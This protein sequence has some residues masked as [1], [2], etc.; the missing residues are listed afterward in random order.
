M[1]VTCRSCGANIT[2]K[3]RLP[4][5]KCSGPCEN[6]YHVKCA[7]ISQ[8]LLSDINN[9]TV[10]WLCE[11]CR[12]QS[13]QSVID[14]EISDSECDVNVSLADIM[15]QLKRMEKKLS[16]LDK[17]KDAVHTLQAANDALTSKL[18]HLEDQFSIHSAKLHQMEADYDK[19]AQMLNASS[20]TIS[21]LPMEHVDISGM[22]FNTISKVENSIQPDDILSIEPIRRNVSK[23]T[24]N[25]T[26][27]YVTRHN[28]FIVKLKSI[29]LQQKVLTQMRKIKTLYTKDLDII[30]PQNH[31]EHQIHIMHRLS[32]FQSQLYHEAKNIKL[33]SNF[34]YLWCK[35]G[36]IYLKKSADSDV[37]R[38]HSMNDIFRIQNIIH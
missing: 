13:S 3:G 18:K 7:C 2:K 24:L 32:K 22:I 30:L 34:K 31:R 37:Y 11:S 16:A 23:T 38:I 17:V 33:S 28:F 8:E 10:N 29:D 12:L 35:A 9:R 20:I 14:N 21:G 19:P 27:N 1:T 5:I 25:K 6:F 4:G 15:I 26:N 36:Q